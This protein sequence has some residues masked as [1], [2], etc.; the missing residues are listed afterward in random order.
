MSQQRELSVNTFISLDGVMQAPG[1]PQEDP[2]GGFSHGGWSVGYWDEEA[3]GWMEEADPYELLLGRGTYEIFAAHWPFAEGPIA[4]RLNGTR[5]YVVSTTLTSLDWSN[6][7][8]IAADVPEQVAALKQQEGPEIQVQGSAGLLQTLLAHDLIDEFRLWT[9]PL[10][11]GTGKRLFG[12]GTKPTG[13]ELTASKTSKTGVRVDTYRR[14][15]EIRG[16]S[17]AHEQPSEA[18]LARRRR[19]GGE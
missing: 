19:L 1:A 5:K 15:G 8:L 3:M 11:L 18:E 9:L 17:F 13:L 16:G 7:T 14:A 12:E 2:S 6:C 4:D 10:V